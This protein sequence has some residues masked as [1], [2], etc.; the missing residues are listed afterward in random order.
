MKVKTNLKKLWNYLNIAFEKEEI[1]AG[2]ANAIENFEYDPNTIDDKMIDALPDDEARA[3]F[4]DVGYMAVN[5]LFGGDF[6]TW[7]D[8][9]EGSLGFDAETIEFFDF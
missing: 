2:F 4:F 3:L 8:V 1:I 7:Y 9:L 5:E 6:G